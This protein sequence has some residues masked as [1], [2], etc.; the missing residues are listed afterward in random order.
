[1]T[2]RS[3]RTWISWPKLRALMDEFQDITSV[4]EVGDDQKGLEIQAEYT[5]GKKRLHMCYAFDFLSQP[6]P[7]GTRVSEILDRFQRLAPDS[8]ACWAYSNHDVE[9]HTSRWACRKRRI[10]SIWRFAACRCR[11]RS[12]CTRARNWAAGS[13]LCRLRGFAGPLRHPV[14]ADV[15]GARRVPHADGLVARNAENGGFSDG[16]PWLPVAMAHTSRAVGGAGKRPGFSMLH[17]YRRMIGYRRNN[18]PDVGQGH[19]GDLVAPARTRAL[20]DPR[21]SDGAADVLCV[22]PVGRTRKRL[23]LAAR[24]LGAWRCRLGAV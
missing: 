6:Y 8:W 7:T 20:P 2:S 9:R 12:A 16:K 14:L 1:M 24:K 10:G 18:R 11:G 4:G 3:P 5:E 13:G 22:Q 17:F 15:Q 23:T 21:P 19:D